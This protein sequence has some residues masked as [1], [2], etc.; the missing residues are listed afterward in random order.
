[1]KWISVKDSLPKVGETVIVGFIDS[2]DDVDFDYLDV[3]IDT[4]VGFFANNS[5]TVTHWIAIPEL[6]EDK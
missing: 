4:G 1:M 3:C 5:D 2:P 6:S